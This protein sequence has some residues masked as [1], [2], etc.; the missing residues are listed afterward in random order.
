MSLNV[1][2]IGGNLTRDPEMNY[3]PA[4]MAI[5]KFTVAVDQWDSRAK[6][7][8]A[9]FINVVVLGQRAETCSTW[10]KKG[11]QVEVVG[12][13]I[14][15]PYTDRNNVER[16]WIELKANEVN[17]VGRFRSKDEVHGYT[18]GEGGGSETPVYHEGEQVF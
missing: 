15:R 7:N 2:I 16:K 3:T 12:E 6:A 4:G 11:S 14:E 9:M 1:W 17:F 13:Y 10:L 18:P 8:V 5:T